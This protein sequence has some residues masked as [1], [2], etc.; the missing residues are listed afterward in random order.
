MVTG[1]SGATK[2][3]QL[4]FHLDRDSGMQ[5]EGFIEWVLMS[6]ISSASPWFMVAYLA[7]CSVLFKITFTCYCTYA[8]KKINIY[9]YNI[10]I[11]I[12]STCPQTCVSFLKTSWYLLGHFLKA[13]L[14]LFWT[15]ECVCSIIRANATGQSIDKNWQAAFQTDVSVAA[16]EV[17]G[18]TVGSFWVLFWVLICLLWGEFLV[19][20]IKKTGCF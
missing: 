17:L 19:P 13:I 20:R 10:N 16:R 14:S 18:A 7:F 9:I 4:G 15:M 3:S 6:C 12:H 8:N 1:R 11:H 2:S 5:L